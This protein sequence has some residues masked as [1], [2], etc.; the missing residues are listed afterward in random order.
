MWRKNPNSKN[1]VEIHNLTGW[2]LLVCITVSCMGPALEGPGL[3]ESKDASG[4][5]LP[6]LSQEVLFSYPAVVEKVPV[7]VQTSLSIN[8]QTISG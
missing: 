1:V 7:N 5:S 2:A 6:F 3:F 4:Q 8:L